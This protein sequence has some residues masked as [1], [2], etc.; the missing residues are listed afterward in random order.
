MN[1][2]PLA[3]EDHESDVRVDPSSLATMGEISV[4]AVRTR[5]VPGTRHNQKPHT[6]PEITSV[7]KVNEKALK[8]R[9][10]THVTKCAPQ[11][12]MSEVSALRSGRKF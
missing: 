9:D 11:S 8:G 1:T 10:L 5:S 2:E 7:E 6:A 3:V 4:Y 12:H